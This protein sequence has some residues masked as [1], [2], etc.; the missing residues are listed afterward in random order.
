MSLSTVLSPIIRSIFSRWTAL[1]LAVSNSMG[2]QDTDVK[3]EAFID[4]FAQY[5]TRNV[6]PSVAISS[7]ESDI[8]D[9]LNEVLDEEF[10][11][12]LDDGS[13]TEL[14]QLFVR[15][16]ELIQQGKLADVQQEVQL[17][18]ATAPS[19][20]MS[21]RDNNGDGSSSSSSGSDD[22]DD[23]E[24]DE[25]TPASNSKSQSMDVDEDGWTTVHRR[26]GAG[27]GRKW[28]NDC[29]SLFEC[30]LYEKKRK[31]V[32]TTKRS[33]S[34]SRWVFFVSARRSIPRTSSWRR[35][36]WWSVVCAVC[37]PLLHRTGRSVISTPRK[38]FKILAFG[39]YVCTNTDI[40]KMISRFPTLV[41]SG[42]GPMKCTVFVIG[43]FHVSVGLRHS[44][45]TS[46]SS[47]AWFKWVQAF[48]TLAFIFTVA[49]VSSL[50]VA[51][52]STFRWHWKYQL[53]WSI[54]SFVI[55]TSAPETV[56]SLM[57]LLCSFTSYFRADRARRLWRV[58]SRPS[59][60]A[61]AG[62]QLLVLQLLAR[63]CCIGFCSRSWSVVLVLW[64]RRKARDLSCL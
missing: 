30:L 13:S 46:C 52:F 11:T 6:R 7:I 39:S 43:S 51:V 41:V 5:L 33:L 32:K 38:I 54:I 23:D 57:T 56:R 36:W 50:A 64:A 44:M 17:Q 42:F 20:Q 4:A 37:Q 29:F 31:P 16:I 3:Y 47:L 14:A 8:Q 22:D 58:Q 49:T 28:Q 48:A 40:T 10:N 25:E 19:H 53:A 18:E 35:S 55:G 27:G 63:V 9:Y 24:M 45:Q 60:D 12:E 1:Q 59:L 21:V 34:R 61:T 62:I 15:Y 26:G 2:G